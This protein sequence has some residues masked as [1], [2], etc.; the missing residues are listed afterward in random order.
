MRIVS[1]NSDENPEAV[2]DI[3]AGHVQVSGKFDSAKKLLHMEK[4][5]AAPHRS[6]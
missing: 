3:P 5:A 6:R 1:R 4:I 2:K